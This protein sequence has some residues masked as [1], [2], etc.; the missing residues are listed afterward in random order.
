[1]AEAGR[2]AGFRIYVRA[3]TSAAGLALARAGGDATRVEAERDYYGS[4]R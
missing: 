2:S 4:R 3:S 1:M